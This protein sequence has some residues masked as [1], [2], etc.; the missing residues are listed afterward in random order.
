[1]LYIVSMIKF[2]RVRRI[3]SIAQDMSI[4]VR[5]IDMLAKYGGIDWRRVFEHLLL[6]GM[7][8]I[9]GRDGKVLTLKMIDYQVFST[10]RDWA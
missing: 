9:Y 3:S 8:H 10:E 1:M 4:I 2:F 6:Y 5:D 7:Y